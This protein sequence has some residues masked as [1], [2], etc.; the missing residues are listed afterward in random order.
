MLT[1][2]LYVKRM[3]LKAHPRFISDFIC[4][5]E[6]FSNRVLHVYHTYLFDPIRMCNDGA[7]FPK[8]KKTVCAFRDFYDKFLIRKEEFK[9]E[10]FFPGAFTFHVHNSHTNSEI[11]KETFFG[12][13]EDYF[14]K[15]LFS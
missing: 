7:V 13:I 11:K 8:D 2:S 10:D 6:I 3:T 4:N 15:K 9:F 14:N 1:S 12:F 5:K